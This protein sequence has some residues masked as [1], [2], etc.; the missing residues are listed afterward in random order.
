LLDAARHES[1][2][3]LEDDV[4]LLLA[5]AGV[6]VLRIEVATRRPP[7]DADPDR[8]HAETR[9]DAEEHAVVVLELLESPDRD[10]GHGR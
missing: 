3:S 9:T 10:V 4:G 7:L 5:V 6:V 8:G 1:R 2:R